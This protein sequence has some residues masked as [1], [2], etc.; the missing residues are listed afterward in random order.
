MKFKNLFWI[1]L[2]L[3]SVLSCEEPDTTY[4][5][6]TDLSIDIPLTS[7]VN[8][9]SQSVM[10]S[11]NFNGIAIFCLGYDDALKN[12]PGDVI[13]ITPGSRSLLSFEALQSSETIDQLELSISYKTQ[14]EAEY[15]Q[16]GSI[17]LLQGS[18]LN[19]E[20]YMVELDDALATLINRLNENPRY[21]IS[22]EIS[23]SANFNIDSDARFSVPLVIE[24]EYH[25]PRFT[26]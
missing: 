22:L 11:Y 12:C 21:Y 13:Q 19:S 4:L 8:T 17:D 2:L 5:T 15:K 14:N 26:L 7:H 6:E 10:E 3:L 24:S 1:G 25:S 20:T 16:I 18:F 23:G 9:L